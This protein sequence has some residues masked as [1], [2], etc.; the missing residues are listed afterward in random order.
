VAAELYQPDAAA[1]HAKFTQQN[2]GPLVI[3]YTGLALW[4]LGRPDSA[5]QKAAEAVAFAE[6]LRHP[7]TQAVTTWQTGLM[8][9]LGGDPAGAVAVAERVLTVAREQSFA[10]WI[11]L[12]TSL[13][14]AALGQLGRHAEAI[15]L[16]REGLQ[17]VEGTGCEMVHQHFLGCLAESLWA[18]GQREEAWGVLNRALELTER[19][20]E[21]YVESELL[22]RK[23]AFLL[24][25]PPDNTGSAT[26]CLEAALRI[27]RGQGAKFFELRAAVALG[28]LWAVAGRAAEA[29]ELVRPVVESFVEGLDSPDFIQAREFLANLGS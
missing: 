14:G 19:D 3:S 20:R 18:N 24:G 10:F 17:R 13:K 2:S 9:Q 6:R 1:G 25:E 29:R 16:L 12:P 5:R 15:A 28:R 22:R 27:A 11:A 8:L 4:A 26:E 23:A 7:F 21:R